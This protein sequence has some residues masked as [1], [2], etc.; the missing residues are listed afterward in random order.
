MANE[1][2]VNS[3]DM[4]AVADA[5]RAKGGTSNAM[6]FPDG[7]VAAVEAIE[8][9]GTDGGDIDSI[10]SGEVTEII[11]N[12]TNISSHAF[13]EKKQL[14]RII[15]DNA[16]KAGEY[17]CRG[18]GMLIEVSFDQLESCGTDMFNGC[19]S[20]KNFN[21][22]NLKTAGNSIFNGCSAL[23]SVNLPKATSI[24]D[25]AF[26]GCTSLRTVYAENIDRIPYNGFIG[27]L[28]ER[29][30]C[31]ANL[32]SSSAFRNCSSFTTLILLNDTVASLYNVNAFSGTSI[33]SGT[34]YIYVHS[35]LV[36]EY[37]AATNWATY[38]DQIRAIE[39]YP[40]ITG[41]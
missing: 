23:E 9:G 19:V 11:T 13:R 29:F 14:T 16:I 21:L 7:F 26:N 6:I 38:A 5:I 27:T 40:D 33:E 20:L 24:G 18:S 35:A 34:G 25:S 37:K 1:Y 2:L 12:V 39:D 17:V 30:A 32:V 15:A 22:P 36:K 10:I 41:G 3:A 8:T 28:V 4:T 31:R